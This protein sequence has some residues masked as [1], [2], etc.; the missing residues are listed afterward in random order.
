MA[1][2]RAS[3]KRTFQVKSYESETVE[4]TITDAVG[5][6]DLPSERDGRDQ[7]LVALARNLYAELAVV[8]DGIVVSRMENA[9]K[10]PIQPEPPV[11]RR[12]FVSDPFA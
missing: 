1:E 11:T 4:L 3:Y 7:V 9:P 12:A 8:A 6:V 5:D 10:A 2:V